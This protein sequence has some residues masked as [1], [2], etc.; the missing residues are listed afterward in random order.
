MLD[1]RTYINDLTGQYN[2]IVHIMRKALKDE[3]I[4]LSEFPQ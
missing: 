4:D 2:G 3:G 1:F